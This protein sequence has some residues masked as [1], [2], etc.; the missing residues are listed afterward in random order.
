MKSLKII[1][2]ILLYLLAIPGGFQLLVT[3]VSTIG[4]IVHQQEGNVIA[5]T[6]GRLTGSLIIEV[7]LVFGIIKLTQS[8]KGKKSNQAAE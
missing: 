3:S 4:C 1:G 6:I 8:L 5:H 7:I 2:L